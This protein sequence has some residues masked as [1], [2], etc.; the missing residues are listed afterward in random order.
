MANDEGDFQEWKIDEDGIVRLD[1]YPIGRR[2][3]IHG[4]V[5][6]EIKDRFNGRV[7]T[8]DRRFIRGDIERLYRLMKDVD[9][10]D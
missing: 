3:I 8:L 4:R 10:E 7:S 6:L 5:I 2:R 9:L 1:G